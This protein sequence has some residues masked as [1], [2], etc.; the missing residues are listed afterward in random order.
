MALS[1][2]FHL[3]IV[4]VLR[5]EAFIP[6]SVQYKSQCG[7][8]VVQHL[9]K[10]LGISSQAYIRSYREKPGH[11]KGG[12]ANEALEFTFEVTYPSVEFSL[13]VARIL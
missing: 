5:S 1:H 10:G 12:Y 7:D 2:S 13:L 3:G 11:S 4:D 9:G 8:V 6:G